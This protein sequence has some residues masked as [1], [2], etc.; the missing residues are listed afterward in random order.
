RNGRDRADGDRARG[1]QEPN[2]DDV[3]RGG[4]RALRRGRVLAPRFLRTPVGRGLVPRR[5]WVGRG[6]SPCPTGER[7]NY[8]RASAPAWA[9]WASCWDVTPETPMAPMI[10]PPT[11]IGI[12]PSSMLAPCR[13]SSRRLA[14]P[15]AMRSWNTFVGRRKATAEYALSR[16][17]S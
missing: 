13:F 9:I 17:T 1:P 2:V 10:L 14:P 5:R 15:C 4:P 6:T 16:A 12:P 3:H 11:T 8:F 7:A